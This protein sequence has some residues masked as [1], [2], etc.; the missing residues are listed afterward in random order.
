MISDVML[1]RKRFIPEETIFLKDDTILYLDDELLITS[2]N[3]LK[4][5]PDMA[6]GIS[7]YYR[8]EGLKIS[9]LADSQ[10]NLIK[11]YCDI[12]MEQQ[13]GN[14]L[15]YSDLL[16]DIVVFPDGTL[17]VL[18]LDEAADALEQGLITAEMLS[19]A[20]RS[21]NRLLETI[22]KNEFHRLTACIINYTE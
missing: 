12:V 8:K 1:F 18:D 19:F 22:R 16:I 13:E 7:A 17:Q 9:R 4:P 15:T 21:A 6:T 5:R 11:W 2:W 14:R 3:A 20:L 10:G